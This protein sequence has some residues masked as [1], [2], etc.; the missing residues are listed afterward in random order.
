MTSLAMLGLGAVVGWLIGY[1]RGYCTGWVD[2][3]IA[4]VKPAF[5]VVRGGKK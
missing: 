2:S 1:Q 3:K 5:R 4:R